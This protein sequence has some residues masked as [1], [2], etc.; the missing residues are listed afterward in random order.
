MLVISFWFVTS[1]CNVFSNLLNARSSIFATLAFT[2]HQLS[3]IF[4]LGRLWK[5][6]WLIFSK[7][8]IP[9]LVLMRPSSAR[10]ASSEAF[11]NFGWGV[12]SSQALY[13]AFGG[14]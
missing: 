4:R 7:G 5:T 11:V 13:F 10:D 1:V 3:T 2:S 9:S 6:F 14:Y 8:F 12:L